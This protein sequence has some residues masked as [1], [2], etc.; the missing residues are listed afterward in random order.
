MLAAVR[1]K[2]K[3]DP[4]QVPEE[5]GAILFARAARDILRLLWWPRRDAAPIARALDPFS[6][7]AAITADVRRPLLLRRVESR[8]PVPAP[9]LRRW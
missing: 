2:L 8:P 3:V 6:L 5:R 9:E 7:H 1:V 4:Q